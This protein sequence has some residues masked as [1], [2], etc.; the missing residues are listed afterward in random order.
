EIVLG[1]ADA[2]T[3]LASATA[4]PSRL[5]QP[6]ARCELLVARK[7]VVALAGLGCGAE[8]RL[9]GV[10]GRHGDTVRGVDI[11]DLAGLDLLL[12]G[13]LQLLAR[14]LEE[15]PPVAEALVLRVEAAIYEI[16]HPL[17]SA[18]LVH[19]HIPVDQ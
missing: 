14:P 5:R 16:W 1:L 12:D 4:S 19:P 6:V 7:D 11:G 17:S 3:L 2:G 15:T 18:R 10:A 13:P 9:A 8:V